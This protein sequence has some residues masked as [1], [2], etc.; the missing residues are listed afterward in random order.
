M[1]NPIHPK[2]TAAQRQLHRYAQQLQQRAYDVPEL[3]D[4]DIP[5]HLRNSPSWVQLLGER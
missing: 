1:T 4:D 5:S 2:V 3:R